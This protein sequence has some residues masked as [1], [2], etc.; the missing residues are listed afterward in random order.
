[1]ENVFGQVVTLLEDQGFNT[2]IIAGRNLGESGSEP[3]NRTIKYWFTYR[4]GCAVVQ[5]LTSGNWL[6]LKS[7]NFGQENF[8]QLAQEM[9][10]E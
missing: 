9:F 7:G 2:F 1:M 5:D 4:T 10:N 6:A 3:W 8:F